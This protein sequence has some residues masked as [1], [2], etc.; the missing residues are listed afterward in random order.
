MFGLSKAQ[1]ATVR[2][3][4]DGMSGAEIARARDIRE[5]TVKK[6]IRAIRDKTGASG[7]TALVSLVAGLTRIEGKVSAP[8]PASI[9]NMANRVYTMA[10]GHRL[11]ELG[12]QRIEYVRHG[13]PGGKAILHLHA[14]VSGFHPPPRLV[15]ALNDAGYTVYTPF[16]PGY[17][18]S[19]MPAGGR[20]FGA[21]VR[22]LAAFA[23]AMRLERFSLLSSTSGSFFGYALQHLLGDRIIHH[24]AAAGYLP[25]DPDL[26]RSNMA[27][28]HR[29]L[30]SAATYRPAVA[31]FIALGAYKML[32]QAGPMELLSRIYG[33]SEGDLRVVTNPA[34]REILVHNMAICS[35]QD[36]TAFI[37]EIGMALDGPRYVPE[38]VA[39][40]V[41]LVHGSQDPLLPARVA[42][43]YAARFANFDFHEIADGGQL[44]LYT[45]PVEIGKIIIDADAAASSGR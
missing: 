20:E 37:S 15:K 25:V 16:R 3:L 36:V 24:T 38:P 12:K 39:G 14:A 28:G 40:P 35:A 10:A 9:T 30:M 43:D 1:M 34:F 22:Q 21:S 4:M 11:L 6:Q 5:D 42:R 27:P 26:L 2:D 17:G 41:T 7:R 45:H 31:R 19:E 13:E 23:D 8:P 29:V 32:V 44:L 33:R 18:L